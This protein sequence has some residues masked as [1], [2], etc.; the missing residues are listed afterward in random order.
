MIIFEALKAFH[1]RLLSLAGTL[2]FN[3][4]NPVDLHR[5]RPLGPGIRIDLFSFL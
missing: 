2:R 3:K 5:P 4:R 1:D